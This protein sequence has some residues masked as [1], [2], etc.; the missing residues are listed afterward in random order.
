MPT[1]R[2]ATE[3]PW[4]RYSCGACCGAAAVLEHEI[5]VLSLN[6]EGRNH[7]LVR[8]AKEVYTHI[9]VE[10]IVFNQGRIGH[11]GKVVKLDLRWLTRSESNC[12]RLKGLS[13][14]RW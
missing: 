1:R 10:R 4:Q 14:S 11:A 9:E 2:P 5:L 3:S 6:G 13:C 7:A 8:L 12:S